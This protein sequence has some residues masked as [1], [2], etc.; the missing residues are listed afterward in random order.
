MRRSH[1][2]ATQQAFA[3]STAAVC[4]AIA[5]L[6]LAV[7]LLTLAPDLYSLDSPELAAAAYRLGIA[8][9]PGYPLYTLSGW[10]FSHAFPVSNVAYRLNLLSALFASLAVVLTFLV[11]TRIV[12][13]PAIAAAAALT[14]GFSYYFWADALA[15]EVYS[16]DAALFA[17]M[18][19]AAL[20]WR[21][22]PTPQ[23]A[24][25]VGL[26]FGLGLATRTTTLLYLPALAA[27]AWLS[28]ERSA[29]SYAA[30]SAGVAAG[31]LF[32]LY[33]PL[34]S[35]AGVHV[36]PGDYGVDGS[37]H[38]GDLA[39][40]AG[41]RDHVTAASFQSDAFAYGPA[42]IL[43]QAGTFTG[44]LV[45]SFLLVGVPLGIAGAWRQWR[46]DRTLFLLLAGC[47]APVAVFFVNYGAIDKEFM[48]LPVYV[49]WALWMAV[50]LQWGVEA[51]AASGDGAAALWRTGAAA[52]LL[53]A[54]ALV[55]NFGLVSLHGEHR[56][57]NNAQEFLGHVAQ[58]GLVYG[59][60]LDVAPFQYLQE[61]E[62]Q[63]PDITL[64]NS[65]TVDDGFLLELA[66]ANVG[67]RPFYITEDEPILR[68]RYALAPVGS[69]F[70]VRPKRG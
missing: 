33:L 40:W 24:A 5:V 8:H 20:A 2:Q 10:L 38:I 66:D 53:P 9:A 43:R 64:V 63:R 11:G 32:Y 55:V 16:L 51:F 70:E 12:A 22:Q 58:G 30:A 47:A 21:A 23:R 6:T 14:L 1:S 13:R 19:L 67:L 62:G 17:G 18:L 68:A 34:R 41:F 54:V 56:P 59:P 57:R 26:L 44:Q 42:E 15:A 35:L 37:L 7:Y 39:S 31:L 36:G 50:G 52:L 25:A 48:F 27:F 65:W 49:V 45:A 28:G 29:R 46:A 3:V 69:G 61:V 60:F 4:A